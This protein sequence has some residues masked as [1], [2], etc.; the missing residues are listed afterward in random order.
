MP[1]KKDKPVLF[2]LNLFLIFFEQSFVTAVLTGTV[3]FL[4][5]TMA[6]DLLRVRTL[7]I[8]V[9]VFVTVGAFSFART[10]VAKLFP[11]IFAVAVSEIGLMF[12]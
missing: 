10:T 11:V 8:M 7:A 12:P 3:T 6:N 1:A 9:S 2:R 5:A 4:P